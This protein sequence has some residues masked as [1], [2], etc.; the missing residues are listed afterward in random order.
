[1]TAAG[2]A[3]RTTAP[4]TA[5]G[6]AAAPGAVPPG[7]APRVIAAPGGPAP[8]VVVV[9][10]VVAPVIAGRLDR[11]GIP[12]PGDHEIHQDDDDDDQDQM[13]EAPHDDRPELAADRH[14]TAE[15]GRAIA[16]GIVRRWIDV[17]RRR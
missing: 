8:T 9:I 16:E 6:T 2:A 12:D 17:A 5:G 15:G 7:I 1:M 14:V 3:V 4:G 13:V 10:R 11:L